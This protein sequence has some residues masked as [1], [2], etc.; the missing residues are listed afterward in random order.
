MLMVFTLTVEV[1]PRDMMVAGCCKATV[2]CI[3]IATPKHVESES[4]CSLA[5]VE[6]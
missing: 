5:I 4:I 6:S 2:S 1:R 3:F